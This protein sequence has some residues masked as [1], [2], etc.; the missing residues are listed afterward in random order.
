MKNLAIAVMALALTACANGYS[1]FYTAVPGATPEA[2]AKSRASPPPEIP[3]IEHSQAFPDKDQYARLGY[4]AVGYSSFNS[5][6]K[7]SEKGALAQAKKV[8]ADLVVIINPSYTGSLTTQIPITTPTTSTS[9]SSGSAT[10]Y[11]AGGTVNAYGN[12]T[13]TTYGSTTSYVPMIVNRYDY[14]AVYFVKRSY[15]FGANWRDLTNE[16][17]AKFQSN[18]GVFITSVVKDS[19]AFRSDVLAGDI[20]AKINGQVIYGSK[21]AS[22]ALENKRGQEV[23]FSIFRNGEL[24][25]KRVM[26]AK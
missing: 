22:E 23:N 7:E 11:G 24:I 21:E 18:S 13:T 19:P 20:I 4:A 25:E 14:G 5:G 15:I 2:I 8:G 26:L 17:T 12:S 3:K 10:A 6:S 1:K 9:Y 16:E